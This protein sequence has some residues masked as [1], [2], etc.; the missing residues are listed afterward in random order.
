MAGIDDIATTAKNI[1]VALNLQSETAMSLAGKRN[2]GEIS[3]STVVKESPGWVARVSVV[4]AGSGDGTIYDA[5][6]LGTAVNGA[7]LAIVDK[8]IGV[9]ELNLPANTGIVFTPGSGM[10]A[11]V[12][13]S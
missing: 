3:A 5:K 7:R 6:S 8:A 9:T 12:T 1:S 2:S 4:V 13:Y 10:T 11:V